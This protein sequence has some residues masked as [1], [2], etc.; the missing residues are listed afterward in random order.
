MNYK[1][2][3]YHTYPRTSKMNTHRERFNRILQEEFIAFGNYTNNVSEFNEILTQWLIEY[4][5][6]RPHETLGDK[7]SLEAVE[8][9]VG[10]SIRWSSCTIL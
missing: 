1:Q 10:L 4:N 2:L 9:L 7:T 8:K 5:S 6:I 3:H